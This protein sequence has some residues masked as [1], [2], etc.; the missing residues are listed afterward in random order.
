MK[1]SMDE[2][3]YDPLKSWTD[4]LHFY[5]VI[6]FTLSGFIID[7]QFLIKEILFS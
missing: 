1:N 3:L 2:E 4:L 6:N 5:T 7:I